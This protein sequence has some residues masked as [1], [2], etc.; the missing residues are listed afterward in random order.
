MDFFGCVYPAP[1]KLLHITVCLQLK[2]K[3]LFNY[4]E[5][6]ILCIV[7]LILARKFIYVKQRN[8]I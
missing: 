2:N 8:T 1:D 6:N 3:K 4:S 5:R 7:F